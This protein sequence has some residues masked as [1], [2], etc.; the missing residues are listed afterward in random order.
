M[1]NCIRKN[2]SLDEND[3]RLIVKYCRDQGYTFSGFLIRCAK[4][5]IREQ[6]ATISIQ[7]KL[8]E[9]LFK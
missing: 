1:A 6:P 5:E 7:G 3:D 2:I 8:W 9:R 4:K